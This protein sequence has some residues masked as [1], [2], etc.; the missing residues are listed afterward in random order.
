M[1]LSHIAGRSNPLPKGPPGKAAEYFR[2]SG[3]G[4]GEFAVDGRVVFDLAVRTSGLAGH[5]TGAEGLVND[6]FDGARATAAFG[7]TAEATINLLGIAREVFRG[8]DGKADIVVAEDVAGTNNHETEKPFGDAEP[9]VFK[10]VARCKK[11]N[12]H[13]K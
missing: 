2:I 1:L 6:G 13:F 5:G 7:A 4:E 11:K 3:G 12:P 9:S 8:T 10:M